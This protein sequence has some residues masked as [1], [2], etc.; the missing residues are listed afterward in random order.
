M[1]AD[2]TQ[3]DYQLLHISLCTRIRRVDEMLTMWIDK[4]DE[5]SQFL[6]KTYLKELEDLEDLETRLTLKK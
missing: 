1:V 2:L 4:K 6:F 3:Q 5:D